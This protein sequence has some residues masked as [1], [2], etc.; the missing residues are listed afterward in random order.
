M[1]FCLGSRSLAH[2]LLRGGSDPVPRPRRYR[3]AIWACLAAA[4]QHKPGPCSRRR[5]PGRR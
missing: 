4:E 5:R 2:M 3:V 1:A